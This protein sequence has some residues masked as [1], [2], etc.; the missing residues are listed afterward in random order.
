[1]ANRLLTVFILLLNVCLY[2]Q[3]FTSTWNTTYTTTGSSANNEITIPTNPAFTNYNY[4]VDWGDGTTDTGVTG[5]ITHTYMA[6]GTYTV[7]ISGVFPSIYFNDTGDRNKIIEIIDWGTIQWETMENAFFGCENINFDAIGAP[8]LSQ[9][10]SLRNMF[11][12]CA[13]FNGIL[14]GWDVSTITDISGM[15]AYAEIFNRPLDL[16]NTI[17]VTDMSFT[18][19][20]ARRFNEP[21]D[22]WNT[23]SVVTMEYLFSEA[24]NFNQNINNWDVSQVTNMAGT[25]RYTNRFDNP[26]NNWI[27]NNVTDMSEMFQGSA[28]NQPLSTWVVDN[29]TNM[30]GMFRE[31]EFNHPIGNWNVSNVTDMSEMFMRH[32][33]FNHP[34]NNWDVSNVTDMSSMFSGWAWDAIYNQPLDQ[35]DVGNVT[36]MNEMFRENHVFNQDISGWDVSNVTDMSHMFEQADSFNQNINDWDVDNVTDMSSM[37]QQAAVFNQPLDN[38]TVSN[39]TDMSNMFYLAPLFNQALNSWDVSQVTN[40]DNMFRNSPVFNHPLHD[41]DTGNVARMENMFNSASSFNQN[42]ATW[43][44]SNITRMTNMLSNSGLSQANY[45]NTLIGWAAQAVNPNVSL[46]ATNLNYCDGRIA[47][48]ELIDNFNWNINGDIINCSFVLCTNLVSPLD[49]DTN[50]PT[51]AN[52]T[53]AAT[54]GAT[55]YKVTVKI[56]R[57]GVESTP[58]DSYDV[59]GGNTVG[60][61]LEDLSGNDLLQAGDEVSVLIV[62]YNNTDGDAV[63]CTEET[64]T[65]VASWVNSP[66]AFKLTYDTQITDADTTPANQL[67][68]ETNTGYP[69]YLTYNYSIDWGDDQ[70]DNN[71]TGDITHTYLAPGVYTISIIGNFPAPYHNYSNTDNIKLVSIDQWGT[72]EWQSML[73]A[74]YYCNNMEYN[75]TDVPDLSTI[76]SMSSMFAGCNLF[77]GNIDNWDVSNVTDM[78]SLFIGARQFN[79]PLNSWNVENVTNMSTMFLAANSFDQPLNNWDTSNVLNMSRMFEQTDVFNQNINNWNVSNVTNMSGMFERAESYNQPLDNWDVSNVTDMS[80]MFNGFVVDMIFN[81]PLDSW[82]VGNVTDMSEMFQRNIDFDQF[83]NSWDTSKVTNMAEMFMDT[84]NFNQPLDNWDVSSVTNMQS[85]FSGAEVFNQDI[86]VWNVTNVTTTSSMFSNAGA[87]NQPLSNWDVN[88]V[89]NMSSMFR[90]AE[91]FNQPL[92]SWD[93]SAVAN[94]SSMFESALVFDQPLNSWDVSS[95]TLMNSMFEEASVF[96]NSIG[97]WNVASVTNMEAMFKDATVFDQEIQNWDTGEVLT[98]EEM[99]RGAAAFNQ[100]LETWDVSFVSTMEGMFEDAIAFDQPLSSWN[101]AS[102]NTMKNMFKGATSFNQNINSWNVRQVNTMEEMFRGASTFN[103]NLN[104]WRVAGVGTMQSMFEDAIAYNQVMDQWDFGTVDMNAMF[105]NATAF[106]QYLGD[107]DV[108]GVNDMEDMLNNTALTREN[109]DNTLISWS[110]QTLTSGI[111]LGADGL[112]Y[113]DALEERQSMIDTF[114]WTI[115]NDVLDCPVPECTVLASPLNG[116]T[117][118]PV[119]TNLTWEPALFARGYRVTVGTNPGSNDVVNN[120]TISETSYEFTNDFGTG[121]IVYV[122]IVPFNDEGDAIGPC[123]EE[124][125]TISSDPATIPECTTLTSP[126]NNDTDVAI[127]TDLSWTPIANAD[128][129]RITV[130]TATGASDIANVDVNNVTSYELTNDL[131][132]DTEIFVTITPYNDEGDSVGCAE[133]SFTT[134]IIPVP[135]V[136]TSLSSPV[137]GTTGVPV[138]TDISWNAV[139]G[140]TGYLVNVGTTQGGI[141]IAN[142]IDVGMDTMY[143]FPED[144][145]QNR[146][147]YVTIIPYNDVGDAVGCTEE[148]FRTGSSSLTD[149]PARTTLSMPAANATDVALNTDLTWNPAANATGYRL[150][151]G[152]SAGATDIYSGAV[153]NVTTWDLTNDLPENTEIFVTI[154]PF[155]TNGDAVGC[156]S[157]SFTTIDHLQVPNCTTLSSPLNNASNVSLDSDISWNAV[158]G[159]TG[160]RLRLGTSA[161]NADLFSDDVGNVLTFSPSVSFVENTT[162]YVT[163]IPYNLDGDAVG[164]Q[165]EEFTTENSIE[166]PSCT[167]LNSPMNAETNVA[168][169]SAISW[170]AVTNATGYRLRVGTSTGMADIY[171][172]DIGNNLTYTSI[173]AFEEN[174]TIF[175]TV[176]PYNADGNAMGCAEEIFTTGTTLGSPDCTSLT[177]PLNGATNVPVTT[178]ISWNAVSDADGYR[179]TIGTASGANDIMDNMDMGNLLTYNPTADFE[180]NT[181]VFITVVPYNGLGAAMSCT[182]E[183]FVTSGAPI[184]DIPMCTNLNMPLDMDIYVVLST[185]ISWNTV[186][187]AD[188]YRLSI[189][190]SSGATDILNREDVGNNTV[191]DLANDLPEN[192]EIFVTVISYNGDGEAAGCTEESFITE[193]LVPDLPVC[194][195][196]NLPMNGDTDIPVNT[197]L[198]WNAVGNIDG[199]ILTIGT[200]DGATDII[201]G[202]NVGL[203]TS[204]ELTEDLPSGQEIFVSIIPYSGDQRLENCSSQSFVTLFEE[205][206]DTVDDN[207][208]YGFSPNGD[209]INDFWTIDGIESSPDNIVTIYNRWGDIVFQVQ[210]YDNRSNA[211]NGT[212]NKKNDLGANE[213][214]NGTYFFTIEV[215]GE[216]NLNKLQGY[217]VIKR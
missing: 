17:N 73:R 55:G 31:S 76:T 43:N 108:S 141:E 88:S 134:E 83:L 70:F 185:N 33:T 145:Q 171:E 126:L 53:W 156:T 191:F 35:W 74:F 216:H 6:P 105:N 139:A 69:D 22:N 81:Q 1:M 176:T 107:W 213:L 182:E 77:N 36:D 102:V 198:R 146:T 3:S 148:N 112:P 121:D 167:Q 135:P 197:S 136:C 103:Q 8:D 82:D 158:T 58:F 179:L 120:E 124:S 5:N 63:G 110:D 142:G 99:F 84:D 169:T 149:P 187:N 85:M 130:G 150:A 193:T 24:G 7:A 129:Y 38:W 177:L 159:A 201:D 195:G 60:L 100:T 92:D 113:C 68:I 13:S 184:S 79:Q 192:T 94:M 89:V 52:L 181:E 123:T 75:A 209:G 214:P 47:R 86:N 152:T 203:T 29:V 42:L 91:A 183:R 26:L 61:N 87:F 28:F 175:V 111:T 125:F 166:V 30:S 12:E 210:G 115:E 104:N 80:K 168:V 18:F 132:E 32:R 133:E 45:D 147:H 186:A 151:V 173:G 155:N 96:N 46:G 172:G 160:Y 9:V 51:N 143:S 119:N 208:L 20:R 59:P 122:T 97:N 137:S 154:T 117:D 4:T 16:W 162:I 114:G 161:G 196:I 40:M 2:S 202:L 101:M 64:F 14:N 204:Y 127:N 72:Q 10:T 15:F 25:F 211:F 217:L 57:G 71:V 62:P 93:V 190:T 106:D 39:V 157:E 23:S 95:V 200:S 54:P 65:V 138:D 118:V 21:L 178:D 174:T 163:V 109:Y 140:A 170:D 165:E 180:E 98:M 66:A 188:G 164:C 205:P 90:R 27:V 194:T 207:T 144:L 44:V 131:P 11:R 206:E 189:G 78:G 215:T 34:L 50:V 128:G 37:F 212:A 49:G 199:Y 41:W 19:N 67:K 153:G 56:L 48:E 116:A